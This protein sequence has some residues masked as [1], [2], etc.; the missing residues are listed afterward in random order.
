MIRVL[1]S[2]ARPSRS[3]TP[4][5]CAG[6]RDPIYDHHADCPWRPVYDESAEW[7]DGPRVDFGEW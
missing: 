2:L 4:T 7:V 1:R 5:E 6:C 3:I